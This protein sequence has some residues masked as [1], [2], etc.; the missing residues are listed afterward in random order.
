MFLFLHLGLVNS[1]I[2][3]Y[4]GGCGRDQAFDFIKTFDAFEILGQSNSFGWSNYYSGDIYAIKIDTFGNV[5]WAK[6][7]RIDHNGVQPYQI[8]N[9][10]S[11]K[12]IIVFDN[13]LLAI[14]SLGHIIWAKKTINRRNISPCLKTFS[15]ELIKRDLVFQQTGIWP[16]VQILDSCG[17]HISEFYLTIKP[18]SGKDFEQFESNRIIQDIDSNFVFIGSGTI[19]DKSGSFSEPYKDV[20]FVIKF[21]QKM[22]ILW[23]KIWDYGNTNVKGL[24]II[25]TSNHNYIISG[26]YFRKL[27]LLNIDKNGNFIWSKEISSSSYISNLIETINNDYLICTSNSEVIM[28]DHKGLVKWS[29]QYDLYNSEEAVK[30]L[31]FNQNY[32]LLK[33]SYS[34]PLSQSYSKFYYHRDMMI[35]KID[36]SGNSNISHRDLN[37]QSASVI[38]DTLNYQ[39]TKKDTFYTQISDTVLFVEKSVR[40][41]FKDSA[42]CIGVETENVGKS[43]GLIKLYPNPFNGTFYVEINE[44][45][46]PPF[47]LEL[48]NSSGVLVQKIDAFD[49]HKIQIDLNEK[50]IGFLTIKLTSKNFIKTQ[51]ISCF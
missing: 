10:N 15:N 2:D 38:R 21:D 16:S 46:K 30:I 20:L 50:I 6:T 4:Y 13:G 27:F 8:L 25:V 49:N 37:F 22:N 28:L 42:D 32:Y 45:Y 43:N 24:N 35:I 7:Y 11:N 41:I 29:Q 33:S 26:N 18:N 14:D 44:I 51:K 23:S 9:F 31:E 40:G 48:Y 3:K 36:S 5:R 34:N 19:T 47:L 39:F 12:F 1:Q 17:N